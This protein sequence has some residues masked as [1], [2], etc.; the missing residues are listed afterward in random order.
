MRGA[1]AQLVEL[2]DHLLARGSAGDDEQ[3][4]ATMPEFLV[5]DS[6]DDVHVGDAAVADPH[7]VAVDDPVVTVGARVGAKVAHVAAAFGSEIAGAASLRSP[8]VPKHSG[9]HSSICSGDA[10]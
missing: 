5:D 1:A 9:A 7:L 10:A 3:G 4:L 2:A 8:G 6:V